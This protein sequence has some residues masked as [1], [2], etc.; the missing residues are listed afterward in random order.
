MSNENILLDVQCIYPLNSAET[1]TLQQV[2]RRMK[3]MGIAPADRDHV[4]VAQEKEIKY[5]REKIQCLESRA[6]S[7]SAQPKVRYLCDR[8]ACEKCI[9]LKNGC[10]HTFDV[11]HAKNFELRGDTFKELERADD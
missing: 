2:L 8:R 10:R 7:E 3:R 6:M 1:V 11:R 9:P 5:Y 4:I